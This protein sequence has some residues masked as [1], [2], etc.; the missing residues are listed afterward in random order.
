MASASDE[1]RIPGDL[2]LVWNWTS[3]IEWYCKQVVD[4]KTTAP[5]KRRKNLKGR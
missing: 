3:E 4:E 1:I 2:E 5:E